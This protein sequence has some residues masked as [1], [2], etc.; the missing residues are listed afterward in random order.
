MNESVAQRVKATPGDEAA[1]RPADAVDH[2]DVVHVNWPEIHR[3]LL[4]REGSHP[5]L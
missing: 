3:P 1:A 2:T 5:E 4:C